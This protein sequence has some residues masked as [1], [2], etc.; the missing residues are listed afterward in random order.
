MK[1]STNSITGIVLKNEPFKERDSKVVVY[2]LE[3][4]KLI[5]SARGSLKS[6]SKLGGH[7]QEFSLSKLMIIQGK[8]IEYIGGAKNIDTYLDLREDLN[9]LQVAG[10]GIYVFNKLV[11]TKAEDASLFYLLKDFLQLINDNPIEKTLILEKYYLS[12]LWQLLKI[13]G[14][15]PELYNCYHCKNKVELGDIYFNLTKAEVACNHKDLVN[16]GVK[17]SANII[18]YL[19]FFNDNSLKKSSLLQINVKDLKVLKNLSNQFILYQFE[20]QL[21]KY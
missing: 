2:S 11:N 6:N 16:A 18:K 5:L 7:L 17:V 19:R 21:K 10:Q 14:Y 12:F 3:A 1:E 9:K 8:V 15:E 13:L 20:E 4:G